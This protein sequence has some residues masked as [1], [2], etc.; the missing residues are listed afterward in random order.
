[1]TRVMV[2]GV[3]GSHCASSTAPA[4]YLYGT[5]NPDVRFPNPPCLP[6]TQC[7]ST[8]R[9]PCCRVG[10]QPDYCC[11]CRSHCQSPRA[12]QRRCLGYYV[13]SWPILYLRFLVEVG[14][15]TPHLDDPGCDPPTVRVA[16][17]NAARRSLHSGFGPRR[18]TRRV[19]G[20]LLA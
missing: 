14:R 16:T 12:P 1:M 15:Q 8:Q 20:P 5:H 3:A 2:D 6:R 13:G 9:N 4:L 10:L 19:L 7:R 18:L 11:L 17:P